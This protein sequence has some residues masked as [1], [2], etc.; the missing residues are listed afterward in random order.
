MPLQRYRELFE[1]SPVPLAIAS[2]QGEILEV[3]ARFERLV[4]LS[5][6]QLRVADWK[7]FTHPQDIEPELRFWESLARH[8]QRTGQFEKRFLR[9]DGSIVWVSMHVRWLATSGAAP[10]IHLF[11]F[12]DL[13]ER[14]A[15]LA[16]QRAQAERLSSVIEA[17]PNLILETDRSG[18]V[19]L[20][21]SAQKHFGGG[22]A[23]LQVGQ[24][25]SWGLSDRLGQALLKILHDSLV[26]GPQRG[27]GLVLGEGSHLQHLTVSTN[28]YLAADGVTRHC[29]FVVNDSTQ[30]HLA[31]REAWRLALN[32]GLTQIPNRRHF[33][34]EA[35]QSLRKLQEVNQQA[36]LVLFDLDYFKQINDQYGHAVGDF[37]LVGFAEL[38]AEH[39]RSAGPIARLGGEEF[40]A[41][42]TDSSVVPIT[43]EITRGF[44]S[45]LRLTR[46]RLDE[47]DLALT[48]SAGLASTTDFGYAIEALMTAADRALYNA[49]DLGRD[50]LV[51]A[52][53]PDSN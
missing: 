7:T 26:H 51:I 3:N 17:A 49:K 15:L 50:Q 8:P 23:H 20:I 18:T 21:N 30:A 11:T 19:L 28:C 24:H 29:V 43:T 45:T 46:W 47:I 44:L 37:A 1:Q 12:F 38:L 52:E 42:V 2:E 10:A 48:A 27:V 34:Q 40:A 32:D 25:L 5:A 13:T 31:E 36:V 53:A 9:P 33:L 4:G 22:L 16:E 41:L 35:R 39:Y 6:A 14:Q